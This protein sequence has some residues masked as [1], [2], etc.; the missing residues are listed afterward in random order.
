VQYPRKCALQFFRSPIEP[1]RAWENLN[2]V[3]QVR[4]I[5]Q[6][7]GNAAVAEPVAVGPVVQVTTASAP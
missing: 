1:L 7:G 2:R 4:Q 6:L 5:R 3:Q